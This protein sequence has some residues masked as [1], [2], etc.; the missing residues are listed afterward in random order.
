MTPETWPDLQRMTPLLTGAFAAAAALAGWTWRSRRSRPRSVTRTAL[1]DALEDA[2]LALDE[3]GRA[4]DLNPA[5]ATLLGIDA[6]EAIGRT[7]SW[8]FARA[9]LPSTLLDDPAVTALAL[10]DRHYA[11]RIVPLVAE[12][13]GERARLLVLQDT[14]RRVEA[15]CARRQLIEELQETL[16]EPP[17]APSEPRGP[18]G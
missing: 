13:C 10:R 3:H 8:L 11:M 12:G 15:A 5:M 14:T 4:I 16:N 6:S 17:H 2:V 9:G 7:G 1:F 18:A